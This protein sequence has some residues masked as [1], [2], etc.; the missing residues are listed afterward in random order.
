MHPSVATR[1][2]L[3]FR[4]ISQIHTRNYLKKLSSSSVQSWP[5]PAPTRLASPSFRGHPKLMSSQTAPAVPSAVSAPAPSSDAPPVA[6]PEFNFPVSPVPENP[7][8]EGRYIKTAA[9]L[10]IGYGS[11]ISMHQL[12]E[13]ADF[14]YG[15]L[16]RVI[17]TGLC[18]GIGMGNVVMSCGQLPY[19]ETRSSMARRSIATLITLRGSVLKMALTCGFHISFCN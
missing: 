10:M 3:T 18:G 8:G 7:L 1:L 15:M 13:L 6:P 17:R 14:C 9:A 5:T 4:P 19:S 2:V 16:V 12:Y 11:P